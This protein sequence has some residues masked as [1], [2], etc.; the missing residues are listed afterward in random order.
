[1]CIQKPR[2]GDPALSARAE[3]WQAVRL[4]HVS[5]GLRHPA[6]MRAPRN[7]PNLYLDLSIY[8]QLYL[9]HRVAID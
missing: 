2:K 1:M 9:R 5:N 4:A 8:L 3:L 6:A 7:M